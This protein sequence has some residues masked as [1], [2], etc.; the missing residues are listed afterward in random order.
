MPAIEA[1][2]D[3]LYKAP[4]H[5][6]VAARTA[7]AKTLQGQDAQRVKRLQKPTVVPW[8]VNQVYWHARPVYDRLVSTGQKLRTA[9]IDAL[10]G[11]ASDV[12]HAT[13]AHR[14]AVAAAVA[15]AVRLASAAGTQPGADELSKTLEAVSLARELSEGQGRLT[16]PLQ[17]AGFEALAGVPVK[18]VRPMSGTGGPVG[19]GRK[20]PAINA[21]AALV[22][23]PAP[24]KLV[25]HKREADRQREADDRRRN[26]KAIERAMA[27]VTR[28][29]AIEARA[30]ATGERAKRELATAE[31]T[32]STTQKSG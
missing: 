29:K 2:I 23:P 13:E 1:K 14:A 9:Q 10:K 26:K 12:R 20:A 11:R 24:L 22:R 7:L 18:A 31:L 3:D 19:A 28:A 8:A 16:K 27:A 32:L 5:G 4:L 15:E 17:P 21:P 25:D 6:F 30:R